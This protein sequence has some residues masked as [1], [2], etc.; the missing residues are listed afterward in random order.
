[1]NIIITSL[2]PSKN[3]II[4]ESI[5]AVISG[6]IMLGRIQKIPGDQ[7]LYAMDRLGFVCFIVFL[8]C[9]AK[10]SFKMKLIEKIKKIEST[11]QG[12]RE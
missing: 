11:E 6:G 10:L 4:L 12:D 8:S 3:I 9:V 7:V 2:K 1:M 5:L